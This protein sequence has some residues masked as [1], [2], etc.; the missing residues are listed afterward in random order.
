MKS[1]NETIT[2]LL[3]SG[4]SEANVEEKLAQD[5]VLKAISQSGLRANITVKGGV[6]MATMTNDIRRTIWLC[7][8]IQTGY[9][10][11]YSRRRQA[12]GH[13]L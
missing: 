3:A 12:T 5:I 1:F 10:S 9:R 4:Y 6:V 8:S 7:D 13:G 11:A 2:A